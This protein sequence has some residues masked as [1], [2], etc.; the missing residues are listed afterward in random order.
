MAP[1]KRA[2]KNNLK[3]ILSQKTVHKCIGTTLS[4]LK[5]NSK[6]LKTHL[7]WSYSKISKTTT[8]SSDSLTD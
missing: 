1:Q 6:S 7:E 8:F 5:I 4:K 3:T 2:P